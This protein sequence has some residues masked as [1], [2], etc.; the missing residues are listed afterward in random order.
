M[1]EIHTSKYVYSFS[2]HLNIKYSHR[3]S[4]TNLVLTNINENFYLNNLFKHMNFDQNI[5]KIKIS[6]T[7]LGI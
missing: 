7:K 4:D 6:N 5:I 3:R 1:N 2:T